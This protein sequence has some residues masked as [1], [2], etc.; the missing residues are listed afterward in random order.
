[1][2]ARRRCLNLGLSRLE[3]EVGHLRA[4]GMEPRS[5]IVDLIK[6]VSLLWFGPESLTRIEAHTKTQGLFFTLGR[7]DIFVLWSHCCL[8]RYGFRSWYRMRGKGNGVCV[9]CI[10]KMT[11]L[12]LYA[13]SISS[14]WHL[15]RCPPN[16]RS[17]N[18]VGSHVQLRTEKTIR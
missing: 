17:N 16:D 3:D 5:L 14:P 4:V 15:H 1:M 2:A 6:A 9:E 12:W 11:L 7:V 10:S 18:G 13:P 8:H